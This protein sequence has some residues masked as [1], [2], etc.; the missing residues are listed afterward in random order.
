MA[1]KV[2]PGTGTLW[3]AVG[4][5]SIPKQTEGRLRSGSNWTG[6]RFEQASFAAHRARRFQANGY[7]LRP[8]RD[9]QGQLGE[10]RP[11]GP[12]VAVYRGSD[13]QRRE[14]SGAIRPGV[15]ALA[16]DP[17]KT[18]IDHHGQPSPQPPAPS[19]SGSPAHPAREQGSLTQIWPCA[20]DFSLKA[21]SGA[22]P[23]L[24]PIRPC[25]TVWLG[26]AGRG[27]RPRSRRSPTPTARVRLDALNEP[28]APSR[29]H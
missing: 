15:S 5:S 4:T 18:L 20:A 19:P 27:Q 1:P 17:P 12:K 26:A 22:A 24:T 3:L 2:D 28:H 29:S 21:R 6:R 11:E 10:L 16:A 14:R 7:A 8:K 9:R 23:G 13:S 25:G